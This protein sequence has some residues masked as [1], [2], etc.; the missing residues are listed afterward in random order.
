MTHT[1]PDGFHVKGTSTLYG[2]DGAVSAQWVK[3]SIDQERQKELAKAMIEAMAEDLP[4]LPKTAKPTGL[5]K[6]LMAC[7]PI[8][9]AHIGMLSWPKETG[10]VWDLEEAERVQCGAMAQL[11]EL[12]PPSEKA[13]IVNLGDFLHYDNS[14]GITARSGNHLDTDGRYPKMAKIAVKIIR[15]AIESALKRHGSVHVI[16]CIGNHDDNGA[17]WLAICLANI[18]ENEPRVTV[19]TTPSVFNYFRHGKVLVG[20]HHGNTAKPDKLQ[21]V[22]AADRPKDWGD[23]SFRYWWGGHIHHDS[24][25][26]F[27]GV[28]FESFRTL[29]SKDAYAHSGGYR[30]GRDM[31]CIVLHNEYGEV[32]RHT[33]NPQMLEK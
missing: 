25:K 4:K 28:T 22:M 19:D 7:Y 21:G 23:T 30:S 18:Y 8:G 2:P 6:D 15:Q 9:D 10:E 33:V 13:T 1:V 26:E 29:A 24:K 32:I 5:N 27:P 17:V 16:N 31:K 11:V 20:C 3:T 12:S 14:E